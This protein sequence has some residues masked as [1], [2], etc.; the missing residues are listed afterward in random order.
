MEMVKRLEG[1]N[2]AQKDGK[3]V[4]IEY[5]LPVAYKLQ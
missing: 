2:P 1:L 3:N 4:S 5:T